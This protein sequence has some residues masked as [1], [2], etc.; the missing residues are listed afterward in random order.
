VRL[1]LAALEL[2]TE[3]GY[4]STT[5][6]QI[7]DRAGLTK[8]TFF[9]HFPDK[10]EVLFAGQEE[11]S[12]ILAEAIAAAPTK[13]TPIEAVDAAVCSL[14]ATFPA[15]RREVGRMLIALIDANDELK[16]RAAYKHARLTEATAEALAARKVPTATAGLAAELGVRAFHEGFA[17]WVEPGAERS[18]VALTKAGLDRLRAA[19]AQLDASGAG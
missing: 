9:R 1:V 3:Q 19:A 14:A 5:V 18:L 16:E 6:A 17:R 15:E 8:T 13:A 11:H 2:C 10:R 4:P 7:A 12:R